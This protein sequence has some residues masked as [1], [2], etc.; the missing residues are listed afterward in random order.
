VIC[1]SKDGR[2]V[3]LETKDGE[4]NQGPSKDG[5]PHTT[6][7]RPRTKK[8]KKKERGCA[9]AI[10]DRDLTQRRQLAKSLGTFGIGTI[11]G[12]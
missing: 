8:K 11:R 10:K 1:I 3:S 2:T 4:R 7:T 5:G 9:R 6:P 12:G